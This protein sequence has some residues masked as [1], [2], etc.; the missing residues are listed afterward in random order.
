M[1]TFRLRP[2]SCINLQNRPSSYK[3]R[4]YISSLSA[5]NQ[6][7]SFIRYSINLVVVK[8]FTLLKVDM[9]LSCALVTLINTITVDTAFWRRLITV[10]SSHWFKTPPTR[11]HAH[12]VMLYTIPLQISSWFSGLWFFNHCSRQVRPLDPILHR[13]EVSIQYKIF[14][15]RCFTRMITK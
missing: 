15:Q 1:W 14:P 13:G 2:W 4:M 10:W 6:S 7:N 9:V 12:Y 3:Y 11:R 8:S 5:D